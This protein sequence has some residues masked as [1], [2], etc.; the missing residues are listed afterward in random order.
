MFSN[1]AICLL[2]YLA[3]LGV[4]ARDVPAN[5]QSFYAA[6]KSGGACSN[7]LETGFFSSEGGPNTYS[8]CGDHLADYGIVYLKGAGSAFVNMD[9]DCDGAQGGPADDGRCKNS[10]DTQSTTSFKDTVAGYGKGISDVNAN[11]HPYVVF[12]N[13]GSKPGWKTFSPQQYGIEPLS[14]M[15]VVCGNQLIYGVWADENG[16]DDPN[17][18]VGE[19]SISL[20]TACYGTDISGDSGHDE[21]DV[22][23]IA[24]TGANAVP[25]ASGADWAAGNYAAFES[26]IETLGNSLISR[27]GG[28]GSGS[29]ENKNGGTASGSCEWEGHCAGATCSSH[30]DCSDVLVCLNDVCSTSEE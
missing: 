24:F 11:V 17:P 28:G 27:I 25:G 16:D 10:D 6:L 1:Q 15:A 5:V 21:D 30:D 3:F 23:Y 4:S 26:S 19:A 12:G 29:R 18:M 2:S 7:P 13:A 14:V 22:L 20:A 8:Y 9:I